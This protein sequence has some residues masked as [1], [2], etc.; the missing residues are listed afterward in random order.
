MTFETAK[1]I[2]DKLLNDEF[3]LIN[4]KTTFGIAIEFIGG[5]P[6]M[7]IDLI[8]SICGYTIQ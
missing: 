4:T 1:N 5:E 8:D 6:F 2:I 3:S 7:E